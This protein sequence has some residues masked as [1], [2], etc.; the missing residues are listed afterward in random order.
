M[1]DLLKGLSLPPFKEFYIAYGNFHYNKVNKILHCICIPILALSA[2]TLAKHFLP[3]FTIPIAGY[4]FT[5]DLSL[6]WVL[7]TSFVYLY[8]DFFSGILSS[9]AYVYL[10]CLSHYFY[11]SYREAEDLDGHFKIFMILHI[12]GWIGN[13][14]GHGIFEKRSPSFMSNVLYGVVAPDFV[15][16]ELLFLL[17]YK[18]ELYLEAR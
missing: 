16:L 3:D 15:I 6:L 5:L 4:D 18:E 7:T 13:F 2:F 1:K 11:V 17:G 8:I 12:V 10:W 9:L 14:V